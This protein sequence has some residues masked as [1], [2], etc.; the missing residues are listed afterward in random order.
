MGTSNPPWSSMQRGPLWRGIPIVWVRVMERIMKSMCMMVE[1]GCK[2]F[3]GNL[4]I[5]NKLLI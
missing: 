4:F 1:D 5:Y 2:G 3:V